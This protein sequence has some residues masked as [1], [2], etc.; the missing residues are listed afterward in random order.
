MDE[1]T[2][3]NGFVKNSLLNFNRN[4]ITILLG[5]A[6]AIIIARALGPEKQGIYALIVLLPNML[7]TFLNIGVSSA[8]VYYIGKEKYSLETIVSTNVF[9]A[10]MMSVVSIIVGVLGISLFKGIFFKDV[11]AIYLFLILSSLP[12]LFANSFLQAIFQGLQEFG[13]FNLVSI[14]GSIVNL[15]FLVVGVFFLKLGVIGAMAAFLASVITPL[16][17]LIFFLKKKHISIDARY[18]SVEFIKDSLLYGYKAHLSNILAFLNYRID[19]LIISYFLSPIAVGV[20]N[21]AVSI[22]EKLW[23]VSQPVSSVLF[24]RISSAKDDTE[25][26]S[27]TA[28]V[29]R[30]VLSLSIIVG[31]GLFFVSDL[32]ISIMFGEKYEEAANLI[33]ILLLGITLFSA[34]R[35]LSNDLAGRGKPELNLY[36]SLFTVVINI[37]LNLL[38]IPKWGFYGAAIATSVAYSLTF[39][40]KVWLFCRTTGTN[41]LSLLLITR[42]DIE[43]YKTF[44][45]K[46][47][48]WGKN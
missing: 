33:K 5:F 1:Y 11:P 21:V 9:L 8:S 10:L 18:M 7:F 26:N 15:I 44:S 42:T 40:L 39:A 20:Y 29:A 4:I 23:I 25:R 22:A 6:S 37:V 16:L 17:L 13:I 28:K 43:L 30:N 14:S 34:E 48:R 38:F 24:P 46:L 35:I 3:Q 2:M 27:L 32:L 41:V 19:I 47:I 45:S 31:I 36:T 12:F